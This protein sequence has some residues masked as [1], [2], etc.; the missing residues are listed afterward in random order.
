MRATVLFVFSLLFVS[1]S[2]PQSAAPQRDPQAL[3]I[4]QK[5]IAAAG[6]LQATQQI[7]DFKASGSLTYDINGQKTSGSVELRGRGLEQFRMD[8]TLNNVPHSLILD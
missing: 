4:L 2:P 6:G 3:S 7:K 5:A 1:S 8:S